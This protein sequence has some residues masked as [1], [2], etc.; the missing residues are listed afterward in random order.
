MIVIPATKTIYVDIDNTLVI[1]EGENFYGH[2]EHIESIKKFYKRGH[3]LVA[4]SAGGA[5]W[6]DH[7]VQS[8]NLESYFTLA[9]GKPDWFIDDL[10]A[11]KFM[12]EENRVF[13]EH[14][15]PKG[16]VSELTNKPLVMSM[17]ANGTPVEAPTTLETEHIKLLKELYKNS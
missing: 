10:P 9:I 6:A 2:P 11:S 17:Y 15:A 8:L 5:G 1:W 4:W 12:P 13:I 16:R 7:A 3:T 14:K